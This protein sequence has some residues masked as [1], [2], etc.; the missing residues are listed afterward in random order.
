MNRRKF[1]GMFGA[2]TTVI[3]PFKWKAGVGKIEADKID[4][5]IVLSE[6]Y[7]KSPTTS[8]S[9]GS[10]GRSRK[11]GY[12]SLFIDGKDYS[13]SC[14]E[15]T[16]TADYDNYAVPWDA[17]KEFYGG[18]R[19]TIE[20]LM[21]LSPENWPNLIHFNSSDHLIEIYYDGNYVIRCMAKITTHEMLCA[22]DVFLSKVRL[23][24]T[25]IGEVETHVKTT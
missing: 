24:F 25:S 11:K 8:P 10:R 2:A 9:S 1:F 6:G 5:S 14:Q 4:P 3:V 13:R 18:K 16:I 19:W 17:S 22:S 12:Y 7:E 21:I 23:I 15:I 20:L